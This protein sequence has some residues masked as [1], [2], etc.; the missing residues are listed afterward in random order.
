MKR[1]VLLTPDKERGLTG[2]FVRD[3]GGGIAT[4]LLDGERR[5]AH[6]PSEFVRAIDADDPTI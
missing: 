3:A 6:Y 5:V 2:R 4:V 1:I